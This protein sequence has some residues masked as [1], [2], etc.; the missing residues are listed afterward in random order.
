M[1][2][3]GRTPPPPPREAA[4]LLP[5]AR[6]A[7]LRIR[8]ALART[9]PAADNDRVDEDDEDD[10]A[11][12]AAIELADSMASME[13]VCG[14]DGDGSDGFVLVPLLLPLA[15]TNRPDSAFDNG[16]DADDEDD[17]DDDLLPSADGSSGITQPNSPRCVRDSTAAHSAART[18]VWSST[19][20]ADS[21]AEAIKTWVGARR[22][23]VYFSRGT[24]ESR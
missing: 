5:D 14:L 22:V 18:G 2:A 13:T 17:D 23:G 1:V 3:D 8:F 6:C 15:P 9:R 11:A 12:A 21:E 19:K 24:S 7:S 16:V 10:E 4:L 20:G